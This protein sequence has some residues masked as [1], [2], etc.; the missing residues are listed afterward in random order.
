MEVEDGVEYECFPPCEDESFEVAQVS[1]SAYPNQNLLELDNRFFCLVFRKVRAICREHE[2][3]PQ[4][5]R[6]AFLYERFGRPARLFCKEFAKIDEAYH[7]HGG[8]GNSSVGPS[9]GHHLENEL[10]LDGWCDYCEVKRTT[11]QL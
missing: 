5:A 3:H 11:L 2:T 6:R 1:S 8:F 4:K 10:F 7:H 9:H